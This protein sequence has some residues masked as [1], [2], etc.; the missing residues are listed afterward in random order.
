M[1]GLS[2]GLTG[3]RCIG[4]MLPRGYKILRDSEGKIVKDDDDKIVI[5]PK[6]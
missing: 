3:Q 2:M 6:N 4:W 5:V 1:I